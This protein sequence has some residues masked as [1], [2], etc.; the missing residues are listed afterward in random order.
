[1]SGIVDPLEKVRQ[2][3]GDALKC[4]GDDKPQGKILIDLTGMWDVV[5]SPPFDDELSAS[6][7]NNKLRS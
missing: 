7:G 1:M 5:S 2:A 6:N 4:D 3:A